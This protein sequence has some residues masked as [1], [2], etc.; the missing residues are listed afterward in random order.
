M[1]YKMKTM[2]DPYITGP[3]FY[4]GRSIFAKLIQPENIFCSNEPQ[5]LNLGAFC[6]IFSTKKSNTQIKVNLYMKI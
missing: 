5:V 6:L 3:S 2:S 1:L 4:L